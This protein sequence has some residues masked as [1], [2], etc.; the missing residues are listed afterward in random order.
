MKGL[1]RARGAPWAELLARVRAGI[2]HLQK[3]LEKGRKG[4]EGL[5]KEMERLEEE[6]ARPPPKPAEG[7]P[8]PET[9][10]ARYSRLMQRLQQVAIGP[11]PA[12]GAPPPE[13]PAAFD[14]AR[15]EAAIR[16]VVEGLASLKAQVDAMVRTREALDAEVRR[17]ESDLRAAATLWALLADRGGADLRTAAENIARAAP[18]GGRAPIPP[19]FAER[20]REAARRLLQAEMVPVGRLKEMEGE[21]EAL[22]HQLEASVPRARL[23]ALLREAE[24]LRRQAADAVP[25]WRVEAQEHEMKFLKK[26]A[27]EKGT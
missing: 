4:L 19:E 1:G 17:R 27:F 23:E 21:A 15:V 9:T 10:G 5:Q 2:E 11:A 3:E 7:A 14:R 6:R 25:K 18:E 12:P 26:M 13:L 22:R 24:E 16:E 20:L 8:P